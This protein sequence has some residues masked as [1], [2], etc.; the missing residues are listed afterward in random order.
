MN[1]IN[2]N[3]KEAG[4]MAYAFTQDVPI[5]AD[6]HRKITDRLGPTPLKGL[7]VHVASAT[8]A[9]T[10]RYTD[11][12]ESK[13]LCDQAFAERIDPAMMDVFKEIGF[14]LDSQ[15]ERRELNLVEVMRG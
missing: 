15:P 14:K 7:I 10:L 9:G 11:V 6:V 4:S 12:W 13:E 2:A 1:R 5:K 3:T 8:P